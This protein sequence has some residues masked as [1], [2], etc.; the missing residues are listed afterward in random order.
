MPELVCAFE[1]K[2]PFVIFCMQGKYWKHILLRC[3]R[4]EVEREERREELMFA[5]MVDRVCSGSAGFR[6][7]AICA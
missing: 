4:R 2:V 6:Q 5:Y 1:D 7:V 3:S